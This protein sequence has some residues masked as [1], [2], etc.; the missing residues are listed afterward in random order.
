MVAFGVEVAEAAVGLRGLSKAFGVV[1]V[2]AVAQ[3]L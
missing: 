2:V 3:A 1:V